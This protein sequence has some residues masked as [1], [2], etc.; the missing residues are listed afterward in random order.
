MG[1]GETRFALQHEIENQK[2]LGNITITNS[3]CK[4]LTHQEFEVETEKLFST[5]DV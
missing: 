3:A 1:S 5:E 4:K 2:E